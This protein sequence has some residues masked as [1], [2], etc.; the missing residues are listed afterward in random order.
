MA[1][2]IERDQFFRHA[3]CDDLIIKKKETRFNQNPSSIV[4]Y[5]ELASSVSGNDR[6]MAVPFSYYFHFL[7]TKGVGIV[8][9]QPKPHRTFQFEGQLTK[10]QIS[11]LPQITE[12]L[13]RL[14]SVLISFHCGF[15]KTVVAIYLAWLYKLKTLIIIPG[16]NVLIDQWIHSIKKFCPTAVI[17]LLSSRAKVEEGADF[18]VMNGANI[19]KRNPR[20]FFGFGTLI[21]DEA[22]MFCSEK[23]STALLNVFPK[24]VIALT[25]TPQRTD[26]LHSI[27]TLHF[28][29][30]MISKKLYRPFI[31]KLHRTG[32]TPSIIQG[33]NGLDW[34]AVIASMSSSPERNALITKIAIS[35]PSRNILILCKRVDQVNLINESLKKNGLGDVSTFYGNEKYYDV[36]TRILVSTFSKSGVGFDFPKLDT[37]IVACS[38]LEG[39]EQYIGRVFRRD[40]TTP[41]II[42][43]IDSFG[44]LV[45]HQKAR[46]KMYKEMGGRM[47]N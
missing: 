21:V 17:Q 29:P 4:L 14:N 27:L 22:H 37:L 39:I 7:A 42:D 35:Q 9:I 3:S 24:Y 23:N 20:D 28:G 41:L 45:K 44:P 30:E 38:V 34:N 1:I 18:V 5:N 25:A 26:G 2:L 36:N 16:R 15:G 47:P 13:D 31:Y 46:E 6:Y 32:F 10:G 40:D 19:S 12:I 33:D 43:F 8:S 11:Y